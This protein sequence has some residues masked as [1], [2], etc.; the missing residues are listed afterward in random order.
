M[1]NMNFKRIIITCLYSIVA[2]V[3]ISCADGSTETTKREGEELQRIIGKEYTVYGGRGYQILEVD[4]VEYIANTNGG[5]CLLVKG[6][7]LIDKR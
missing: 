1:K 3:V 4:G 5:I 6:D 7:S 2:T